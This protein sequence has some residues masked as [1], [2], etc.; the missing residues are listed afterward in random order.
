MLDKLPTKS[1]L[2]RLL[3]D[4][5]KKLFIAG[6]RDGMLPEEILKEDADRG[7]F[8]FKSVNNASHFVTFDQA[9]IVAGLVESFCDIRI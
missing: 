6:K 1:S 9:E 3:Q 4:L 7:G 2:K 5:T 8:E